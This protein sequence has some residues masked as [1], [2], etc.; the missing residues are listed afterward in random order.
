MEKFK[1]NS[2]AFLF[3]MPMTIVGAVVNGKPNFLAVAWVTR[4]NFKPPMIIVALGDHYTRASTP[5]APSASTCGCLAAGKNR[6]L[7][8]RLRP[9]I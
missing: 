6:L 8:D 3:P 4:A 7:R 5:T 1:I 9:Q 2:N